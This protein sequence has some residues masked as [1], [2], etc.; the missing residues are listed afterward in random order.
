MADF[1][2]A[3]KRR[4]GN[5]AR[6]II[7]C[8]K[9][10]SIIAA[11]EFI[12]VAAFRFTGFEAN[13]KEGWVLVLSTLIM[14]AASAFAVY[15]LILKS[16]LADC[17]LAGGE[18]AKFEAIVEAIGDGVTIQDTDYNIIYQNP[19]SIELAGSHTGE[20]CYQAYELNSKMCEGCQLQEAFEDGRIHSVEREVTNAKGTKYLYITASP[21]RGK[22]GKIVAG[23]EL[24]RDVTARREIENASRKTA[25]MMRALVDA[26][27]L[28]IIGLTPDLIVTSWNPAAEQ[29]FGWA[30]KE[31]LGKLYPIVPEDWIEE[32]KGK[33]HRVL[34]GETIAGVRIKRQRK[35]GTLIDLNLAV[36]PYRDQNGNIAGIV[37]ILEDISE[38][39]LAEEWLYITVK[40]WEDTFNSIED[41]V[42]ILDKDFNIIRANK[43]A[44]K[45]L[46]LPFI[47]DIEGKKCF[48]YFH[49]A[50]CPPAECAGKAC[51]AAA[52]PMS[53]EMY[54][55]HLGKFIEV[56]VVPRMD[57]KGEPVGLIHVVRDISERK[58]H[59]NEI[60][61]I[62]GMSYAIRDA[63]TPGEIMPQVLNQITELL[64]G[65][66]AALA[67]N[68][69]EGGVVIEEAAGKWKG[70][71]GLRLA[72]GQGVIGRVMDSGK[73]LFSNDA[74]AEFAHEPGINGGPQAV[75]WAPLISQGHVI[76]AVWMGRQTDLTESEVDLLAAVADISANALARA[77]LYEQA[78][79]RAE[80]LEALRMIDIAISGSFDLKLTFSLFLDQV[81]GK[82]HA[83]AA[84]VLM[85]D[86]NSHMLQIIASKGLNTVALR[87]NYVHMEECIA[88]KAFLDRK[89]VTIPDLAS[90]KDCP[91]RSRLSALESLTSAYCVP[92]VS[93][94]RVSGV[95]EVFFRNKTE[96]NPDQLDFLESLAT[97]GAIAVD[98]ATLFGDLQLSN[99]QLVLAY[100]STLEGWSRAL[101]LRDKETEGHTERVVELTMKVARAM[102]LNETELMHLRRGALLHDIG[103]MGIPD[104]VLLKPGPLTD[105]EWV[106]MR[107]HPVYAYELL[108]H[109]DFLL[110]A[111]DIPYCHHEKW[112]GT[113]YPRGLKKTEIPL[114]ARIFAIVDVWDALRSDRPYRPAWTEEVVIRHIRS[115]S[116]SHFDPNVVRQF[117]EVIE[118]KTD[119]QPCDTTN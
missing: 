15:F 70:L 11:T 39:L 35:D 82:L 88:G 72:T 83:D 98:N 3:L 64:G 112:D 85:L 69:F 104:N 61:A 105:D 102:G 33:L 92:L 63:R 23:I 74:P 37:A 19:K 73:T 90:R 103:K 76:G 78:L 50:D 91:D 57:S 36:A 18:Q 118:N 51:L 75:A 4:A 32:F 46:G 119:G 40:D 60:R 81:V 29:I 106:V 55:P 66:C 24:V 117:L 9:L 94:G 8:L 38:Q 71:K 48:K 79:T 116:G 16:W 45:I 80:R 107:R 110:P 97:Q 96:L 89:M 43:A 1:S 86:R 5:L 44:Q 62:A 25:S 14:S 12:I 114:G 100:D 101:D 6:P 42:T 49:G 22:D 108:K 7:L 28:G 27:P 77:N 26:S 17:R 47:E 53:F 30:E 84:D 59:E 65:E 113:G 34:N 58:K 99:M 93:K 52:V 56:R 21:L 68:S 2:G 54:E 20:R 10:I 95:L 13:I 31:V 87:H 67:M 111:L 109:I 41:M 115:L